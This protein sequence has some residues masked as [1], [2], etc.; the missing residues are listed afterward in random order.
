MSSYAIVRA[1]G[2]QHR[3]QKGARLVVD[4]QVGE[5][6]AELVLDEVLLLGGGEGN[7]K[8]GRPTVAGAK[9]TAKIVSH[10]RGPKVRVFKRRKRKGFHKTIGHRQA[11][12]ELE[13]TGI[14]G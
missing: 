3:V 4:R 12:T 5:V 2:K 11:L 1:S 10:E 6:G 8:I 14:A 13:I 9:V 7:L